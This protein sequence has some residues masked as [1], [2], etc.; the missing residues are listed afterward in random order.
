VL[1]YS[2]NVGK[3]I[4]NKNENDINLGAIRRQERDTFE[5]VLVGSRV[6]ERLHVQVNK[7]PKMIIVVVLVKKCKV[8]DINKQKREKPLKTL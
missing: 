8:V 1:F 2:R 3:E 5:E 4:T 6:S 7:K